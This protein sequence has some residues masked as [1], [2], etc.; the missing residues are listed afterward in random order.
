[1]QREWEVQLEAMRGE[2][3]RLETVVKMHMAEQRRIN[4]ELSTLARRLAERMEQAESRL[5][6]LQLRIAAY[7][8][9]VVAL[10]VAFQVAQLMVR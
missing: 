8:G 6:G 9:G 4:S 2:L 1:M 3:V 7:T 5:Q 10:W